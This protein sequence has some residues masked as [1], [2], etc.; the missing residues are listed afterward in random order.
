MNR[1]FL[2]ML[3]LAIAPALQAQTTCTVVTPSTA[4][5]VDVSFTMQT[6]PTIELDLSS[7]QIGFPSI[8]MP[9]LTAGYVTTPGTNATVRANSPWR[10][11]ISSASETTWQTSDGSAKPASDLLWSTSSNGVFTSLTTTAATAAQGTAGT[12]FFTPFY[13]RSRV[14]WQVDAPGTYALTLMYTLTAP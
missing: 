8:G 13:L 11:M 2:V 6:A 10:L 5:S 7:T 14:G 3:A 1:G 4:C 12:G 9:E